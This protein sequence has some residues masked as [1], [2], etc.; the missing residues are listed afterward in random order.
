MSNS[1]PVIQKSQPHPRRIIRE[2]IAELL[3][4]GTDI[5]A[6]RWF[7]S[8]PE[9]AF[10]AE[11]PCGLIY[12]TEEESE[13]K[14][15]AP[16][17]YVR[18]LH[19]TTEV[20]HSEETDRPGSLDDYLDSRAFEIERALYCRKFLGLDEIVQNVELRRTSPIAVE[21]EGHADIASIR[22]FWDIEYVW[23]A[24]TPEGFDEFLRFVDS[25]QT[26]SPGASIS[27]SVTIRGQ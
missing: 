3:K 18:T 21:M 2:R 26:G 23:D 5:P 14:K 12:F 20:L 22:L 11:L 4:A 17:T 13:H 25:I 7:I 24:F 15:T 1:D 10:L 6:D 9:P 19:V 8:R 16:R 27:D